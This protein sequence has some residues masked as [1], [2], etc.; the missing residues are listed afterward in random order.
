MENIRLIDLPLRKDVYDEIMQNLTPVG[1]GLA[2]SYMQKELIAEGKRLA[3][4][5]RDLESIDNNNNDF[6]FTIIKDF[7]ETLFTKF[8]NAVNNTDTILQC[9]YV[10]YEKEE[11]FG[12]FKKDCNALKT[13]SK[14]LKTF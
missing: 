7:I 12:C 4:Y 11:A 10:V 13:L 6:H 9:Y 14:N 3:E 8:Q 5:I 1:V 2:N